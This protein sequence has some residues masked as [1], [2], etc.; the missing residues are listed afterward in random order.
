MD[1]TELLRLIRPIWI[2]RTTLSLA[3]G[4]G[5]REDLRAQLE[6]FF[7][8]MEQVVDTGDTAWLDPLL[9]LWSTSLTQTDLETGQSNMTQFIRE[10][11]LQT[12][13]VCRE[14]LDSEKALDVISAVVPCF[15]HAFEKAAYFEMQVRVAYIS[16]QLQQA[17]QNLERLDRSKSDFI[18]VAAHELKTPLTLI[19]GY[20]AM[21]RE[22]RDSQSISPMELELLSGIN[23]GTRRL[24]TIIDDM[25]DVSMI[26]NNLLQLNFQ[27]VWFNRL[28]NVLKEEIEPTMKERCQ[29]FEIFDFP[30]CNEMTFGD[31]ERL[32]QVFRN[33]LTNAIKYTPD[34]GRISINGRKLPG[35]IEIIIHD[36]GIGIDPEDQ[37]IIFEKF[38][39]LGNTALHSSGKTKF[40]GGGPGL[41]LHIAKGIVEAHGGAIWAES[42]GYDEEKHPGST[43]HIL[44]P[45]RGEPP[46]AR[47]A[48]LLSPLLA[49]KTSE[50]TAK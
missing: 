38:T 41:G 42:L 6:R 8:L 17:Q 32:M 34:G 12:N 18:A 31:P 10:I 29:V 4:A 3:K 43:F 44:I 11:M 45:L 16:N 49:N 46:D 28:L 33:V 20:T 39:R 48:Q 22:S 23:S 15:A 30:G 37:A 1:E 9:S 13:Q 26:D 2:N 24:K 40:K 50:E 21:L 47:M 25:I 27:P 19:E 7:D 5:V 36:T 35:F 14:T